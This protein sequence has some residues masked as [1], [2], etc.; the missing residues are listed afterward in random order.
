MKKKELIHRRTIT[1]ETYEIAENTL[2]VEGELKD[3]R[4]FESYLYTAH[5]YRE[6]GVVHDMVVRWTVSLPGPRIDDVTVDM[7]TLPNEYCTDAKGA[8]QKLRGLTIKPGFTQRSTELIGGIAGCIHL[9]NLVQ[10]MASA[11]VQGQWA[12]FLRK[13]DSAT[14]GMPDFDS[15]LLVNSCWLWRED[16]PLIQ[17]IREMEKGNGKTEEH[18]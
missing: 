13:R 8:L 9:T 18:R 5:K 10:T 2:I 6:P 11:A 14:P 3:D 1:I 15:S 7:K 12:Y 16:G 17:Q 4:F